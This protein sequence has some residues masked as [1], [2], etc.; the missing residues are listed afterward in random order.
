MVSL[1]C[2]LCGEEFRSY[3]TIPPSCPRCLQ[4]TRWTT[5]AGLDIP[6]VRWELTTNDKRFLHG[7]KVDVE[8]TP[9][10]GSVPS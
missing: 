3:G 7:I 4:T 2:V 9:E 5:C 1:F 8:E 10:I 6:K